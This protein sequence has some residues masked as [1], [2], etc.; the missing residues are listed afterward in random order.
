MAGKFGVCL[1]DPAIHHTLSHRQ[2]NVGAASFREMMHGIRGPLQTQNVGHR[3]KQAV[4][5]C[6][7]SICVGQ[8]VTHW[9]LN[10]CYRKKLDSWALKPF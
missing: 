7:Q 10:F 9:Y 3:A 2:S 5:Q 6:L 4:P 8:S 1:V